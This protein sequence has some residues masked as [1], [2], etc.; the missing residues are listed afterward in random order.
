MSEAKYVPDWGACGHN[1]HWTVSD[2]IE[3]E[4][5]CP[6]CELEALKLQIEEL[7]G[8]LGR[9]NENVSL[10]MGKLRDQLDSIIKDWKE[11][12][13]KHGFTLHLGLTA[14][15]NAAEWAEK[16]KAQAGL[17]D[18][19]RGALESIAITT[20]MDADR[21]KRYAQTVL[22]RK[23]EVTRVC[24]C[25]GQGHT[26]DCEVGK[27]LKRVVPVPQ[28]PPAKISHC[29]VLLCRGSVDCDC[30]CLPCHA[31]KNF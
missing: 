23:S 31:I 21:I 8:D 22:D 28:A 30:E 27:S 26:E 19:Y 13:E 9:A 11:A 14:E 16:A 15:Q 7:K 4:G 20:T 10:L 18:E 29:M 24:A 5:A 1:N 25:V 3:K 2:H 17:N 12:F 6:L